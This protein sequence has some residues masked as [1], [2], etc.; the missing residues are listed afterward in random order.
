M[1]KLWTETAQGKEL[2]EMSFPGLDTY[3]SGG[4]G[5]VVMLLLVVVISWQ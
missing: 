3:G 5:G 1:S 2:L 4:D